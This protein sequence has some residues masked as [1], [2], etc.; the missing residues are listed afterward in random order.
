MTP[1][2]ILCGPVC[3]RL[4]W[5]LL[6]FVWQGF[7]VAAG[8]AAIGWLF[9]LAQARSRYAVAVAGLLLLACC[10]LITFAVLEASAPDPVEGGSLEVPAAEPPFPVSPPRTLAPSKAVAFA[11]LNA[12]VPEPSGPSEEADWR[13]ALQQRAT[14]IQPYVVLAWLAGVFVLSARL[15][16]SLLGVRRLSRRRLPISAELAA[17]AAKL[18]G[19]LGLSGPPPVFLSERVREA[20]LVGLWRPMILLPVAWMTEMT[21]DVLEAV[22]AH[23]LA[24]VR[25]WDLWTNL[26]QRLV[27]TLLF[28]HPAVWWLS[29]RASLQ[30]EMCADEL[31]VAATGERVTYAGV[32]EL[33]GR[34]RLNLPAPQLAASMGGR[35]MN[36]FDRVRNVLGVV[37]GEDRLRWWPAG[38]LALLVPLGIWLGSACVGSAELEDAPAAGTAIV[39]ENVLVGSRVKVSGDLEA[40]VRAKLAAPPDN[41]EKG[42]QT[43][44]DTKKYLHVGDRTFQVHGNDL[45]LLD[46]W[47]VSTWTLPGIERKLASVA[48]QAAQD[49]KV[50]KPP[51]EGT[52]DKAAGDGGAVAARAEEKRTDLPRGQVS[53]DL[54]ELSA[55]VERAGAGGTLTISVKN[56]SPG[57]L[58]IDR[59]LIYLLEVVL[60]DKRDATIKLSE[61]AG[62]RPLPPVGEPDFG[63]LAPQG[64]VSR[65]MTFGR[66]ETM[67]TVVRKLENV[68]GAMRTVDWFAHASLRQ[69]PPIDRVA[70]ISITFGNVDDQK[71]ALRMHQLGVQMG[72]K[73]Y[74]GQVQLILTPPA[75]DAAG[76]KDAGKQ[77]Q[78]PAEKTTA[79]EGAAP[80]ET[81]VTVQGTVVDAKTGKPVQGARVAPMVFRSPGES[82][83]W[84]RKV[85]TDADGKFTLQEVDGSVRIQVAHPDYYDF[86]CDFFN[87]S[88]KKPGEK[89]YVV[90][91][92]LES[93]ERLTGVVKDRAGKP[94]AA[95]EVEDLAG[96]KAVTGNDGRFALKSIRLNGDGKY[97]LTVE[98]K[99]YIRQT[100]QPEKIPAEE[101]SIVLEP[102]LRIP[103]RVLSPAGRPVRQF[104]VAAGPG[105]NPSEFKCERAEVDDPQG[106]WELRTEHRGTHWVGVRAEGFA[107]WEGWTEVGKQNEPFTVRL[108]SGVSVTGKVRGP[109]GSGR[110]AQLVLTP[111]RADGDE[112]M[113]DGTPS[114]DMGVISGVSRADGTFR[115]E[116]V[117]PDNYLL[118]VSGKGMTP[119]DLSLVVPEKGLDCGKLAVQGTGRVVGVVYDP[120]GTERPQ[121][122]E[123]GAVVCP[124]PGAPLGKSTDRSIFFKADEQGRFAAEDV[125]AGPVSVEFSYMLSSDCVGTHGRTAVVTEG[126]TTEIR[127]FDPKK[128]WDLP[129]QV[130]VGD[131]SEGQFGTGTGMAAA[132]K[133]ENVTT[134]NP[135]FLVELEPEP[136]QAVSFPRPDWYEVEGFRGTRIAVPDVHPGKYRLRLSDFQGSIGMKGM[137]YEAAIEVPAKSPI[138][139]PLAASSITGRAQWTKGYHRLVM[140]AAVEENRKASPRYA[141]CDEKGNFCL[142]YLSP[143]RYTICLHDDDAGF[144]RLEHVVLA[145]ATTIA[146]KPQTLRPG[147]TITGTVRWTS[148]RPIPDRLT[149]TDAQG[150][151]IEPREHFRGLNGEKYRFSGLWP[152]RW[153]LAAWSGKDRLASDQ[154]DVQGT[155]TVSCVLTLNG[156]QK[157]EKPLPAPSPAA[158][159]AKEEDATQT[160]PPGKEPTIEARFTAKVEWIEIEGKRKADAVPVEND[161]HWLLGIDILS[162]EK[163]ERP[164]DKNG[165]AV[166]LIHSPARLF[167]GEEAKAPG[168]TYLFKLFGK[169]RDGRPVFYS[170]QAEENTS[171]VPPQNS[172]ERAA[173]KGPNATATFLGPENQWTRCGITLQ[174]NGGIWGGATVYLEGSGACMI[175]LFQSQDERRFTLKLP[176]AETAAFRKACIEAD[177]LTVQIKDRTG[178]PDEPKITIILRNA[179]GKTHELAKWYS[180][181]IPRLDPF[182][183]ALLALRNKTESLKPE[184]KAKCQW[185]WWAWKPVQF[186]GTKTSLKGWELYMWEQDGNSYFALMDGTN[187]L[188]S[189]EEIAKAAVK[190]IDGIKPKLDELQPGQDV[191]LRGKS[192]ASEPP[193]E[194][195]SVVREY[196]KKVGLKVALVDLPRTQA[197][198]FFRAEK[199]PPDMT[200]FVKYWAAW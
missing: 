91:V 74:G 131:G 54:V 23:E 139:I 13:T 29:R 46:D 81:G 102:L 116:H 192:F 158:S 191:F 193:K 10:P 77:P 57:D 188:K 163:A 98:A 200:G 12:V 51:A 16:A 92:A 134:R 41:A 129:L 165:K 35:K 79:K 174:E 6:H 135:M 58:Y 112:I 125:P 40:A 115:L 3:Q 2:E 15:L 11:P 76:K 32:L 94:L 155:E 72:G 157:A 95:V 172:A 182:H 137:V 30:R 152:G 18:A 185:D 107:P 154:V 42:V 123:S 198:V 96:K 127:F 17:C 97:Y 43:G 146:V 150:I 166:L 143:G 179:Q 153:T 159:A 84:D 170:A 126:G 121:P 132:L 70:K 8:V 73:L 181:K 34:R 186:P 151:V 7:L 86:E 104:T 62:D 93:G 88:G 109:G 177:L 38:L 164:F 199:D 100:L 187:R 89:L 180:D 5:T 65:T 52:A 111:Q 175:S 60:F 128:A 106:R 47:G 169:M 69:M 122:F 141:Y 105:R 26:L 22:I 64:T 148:S 161:P 78:P 173:G 120:K 144:S 130:V 67:V 33:L 20:I 178:A 103:G 142:R 156:K 124:Y 31:A 140:V 118:S 99:G 39:Y 196:C 83:D 56:K 24:H 50:V 194:Q 149:L 176:V 147:G 1:F 160:P 113:V 66:E 44:L 55:R 4:A 53:D 82:P 184:Y 25:R 80:A 87:E 189:D 167:A 48:G 162:V 19:R 136:G 117:R 45:V 133:V 63:I 145:E 71:A 171:P 108:Q 138:R 61:P 90:R 110:E 190:G 36:L 197:A 37:P 168:K 59:R 183:K 85:E 28:Y 14:A 21:P 9:R 75:K 27:E 101:M 114:R 49:A 195:A 119:L 68:D